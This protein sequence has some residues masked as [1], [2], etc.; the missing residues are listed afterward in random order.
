MFYVCQGQISDNQYNNI[1]NIIIE[2]KLRK[3]LINIINPSTL[4]AISQYTITSLYQNIR[5]IMQ[6]NLYSKQSLQ[7]RN[8]ENY[9]QQSGRQIL[10]QL[11]QN[12]KK[13]YI[14]FLDGILIRQNFIESKQIIY[15]ILFYMTNFLITLIANKYYGE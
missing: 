9:F 1:N 4:I 15:L 14:K 13:I 12:Q 10:F 3:F 8:Q 6:A 5:F 2:I 11:N 7:S